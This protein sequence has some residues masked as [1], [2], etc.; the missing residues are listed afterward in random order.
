MILVDNKI[1]SDDVLEKQFVCDL[2]KCKGACCEDGDAGAPLEEEEK[3]IIDAVYDIVR[4]YL[5]K[6]AVKEIEK[7]GKYVW[8]EEFGWVTPTLPSDKEICVYGLREKDGTIHCAF[9]KAYAEK[10]IDWKKPISCHLYPIISEQ[11]EYANTERINYDPRP[12]VCAP[13]CQLGKKL[14][15]PVYQFLKEPIVRK[16]GLPF[17]EAL[18]TL[19]KGEWKQ[20]E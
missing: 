16:W 3:A 9:E 10:K 4:P 14:K 11:S 18:D 7:N 12:K 8:H 5:T 13:A 2:T 15:V 20:K 6:A 1:I 17:W 19:A